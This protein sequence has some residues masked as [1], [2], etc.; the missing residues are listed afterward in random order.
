MRKKVCIIYTGGTIGMIP[1]EH[2][3]VPSETALNEAIASMK[4]LEKEGMPEVDIVQFKPL[5]DSSNVSI[6]EYGE[7]SL[8]RTYGIKFRRISEK[9]RA[10]L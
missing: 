4:D 6:P 3:Y 10:F 7:K 5:L 9:K 8:R 1:G 2:G